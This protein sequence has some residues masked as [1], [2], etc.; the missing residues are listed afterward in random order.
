MGFEHSPYLV[1]KDI[2]VVEERVMGAR[3][4]SDNIFRWLKVTLNLTGMDKYEPRVNLDFI[5]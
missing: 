1:T 4:Y 5:K 2:L 3:L